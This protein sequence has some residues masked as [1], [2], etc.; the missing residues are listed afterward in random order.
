MQP[1]ELIKYGS[2]VQQDMSEYHNI[3]TSNQQEP[4]D[5]K[6]KSQYE[7][8]PLYFLTRSIEDPVTKTVNKADIKI[9]HS[10]KDNA[11]GGESSTKSVATCHK[12]E[13]RAI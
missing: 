11:Y 1:K 4:T 5:I 13:K 3:V 9:L 10:G 12:C 6:E 8:F 2:L 7:N